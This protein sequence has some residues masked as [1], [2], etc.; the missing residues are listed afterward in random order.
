[1]T[2]FLLRSLPVATF[3]TRRSGAIRVLVT[4]A[5]YK[6]TK[7]RVIYWFRTDLRLHDSPALKAALDLNPEVLYP[8][9]TVSSPVPVTEDEITDCTVY[10]S[11][12]RTMSIG[13]ELGQI[14]GNSCMPMFPFD[15]LQDRS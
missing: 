6:G 8:I 9:W 10:R 11:G 7:P 14:D 5:P 1:M 3:A 12:I 15:G 13:L 4:M 2:H